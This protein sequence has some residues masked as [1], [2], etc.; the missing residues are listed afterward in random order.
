MSAT[1]S[2]PL[3][4]DMGRGLVVQLTDEGDGRWKLAF[5]HGVPAPG[6]VE[7]QAIGRN[8][9]CHP[10]KMF[11]GPDA[12]SVFASGPTEKAY[13]VRIAV[14]HGDH[15]HLRDVRLPGTADYPLTTGTRGGTLISMGHD[16]FVEVLPEGADTLRITFLDKDVPTGVPALADVKAEVI[17][18]PAEERQ[19]RSLT[20]APGTDAHS[21][22]LQGPVD[23]AAYLRLAVMMGD[24][25][26]TRCAPVTRP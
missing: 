26:H 13:R 5:N 20:V 25:Y 6:A 14:S 19:V 18:D 7:V 1:V 9:Q 21:L 12:G 17:G 8:G 3:A 2:A 23:G 4:I 11:P 10:M 16:S 24:H 22:L 15:S